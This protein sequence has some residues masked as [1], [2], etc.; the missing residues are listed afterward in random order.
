LFRKMNYLL[1]RAKLL[2]DQIDVDHV[3]ASQL[4]EI[5]RFQD[6]AQEIKRRLI[7]ANLRLVVSIAKRHVSSNV[8]LFELISDGNVS[9]MRAVE[10]FDY[11]RGFKFSTYASWAI[12]KNF[13]RTI[14]AENTRRDRFVTGQ[15]LAFELTPDQRT[16][17]YEQELSH[18]RVHSAVEDILKKL[19]ERERQIIVDRYGLSEGEGPQTLEQVGNKFGVTK[20][21]IRQIEARAISKLRQ[22]A[23]EAR[24]DLSILG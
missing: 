4:D 15:E 12:M 19:D 20:E 5:E 22:Y 18:Q 2:R 7:R 21:R 17:E 10:K 16:I 24:L 6:E 1:H 3:K 14:P 11:S 13:A 9:L 23:N 8:N